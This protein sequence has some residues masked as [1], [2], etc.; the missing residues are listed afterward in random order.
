MPLLTL[1]TAGASVF[2][3]AYPN[4][5]QFIDQPTQLGV[6]QR[7]PYGRNEYLVTPEIGSFTP[8]SNPLIQFEWAE[9]PQAGLF[10]SSG[11]SLW[12]PRHYASV[13]DSPWALEINQS[14]MRL[15]TFEGDSDLKLGIQGGSY[16]N[17]ASGVRPPNN[18]RLLIVHLNNPRHYIACG[19]NQFSERQ[20]RYHHFHRHC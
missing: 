13:A 2:A 10:V 11:T 19:H 1:L 8:C 7:N 6:I 3:T 4:L 14:Q 5:P 16:R 17:G 18:E 12:M 9:C 15:E 20:L